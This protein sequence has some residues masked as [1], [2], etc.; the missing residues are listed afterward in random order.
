MPAGER[1]QPGLQRPARRAGGLPEVQDKVR[2]PGLP[3]G[4]LTLGPGQPRLVVFFAA[5]LAEVSNRRA[6]LLAL[7]RY[8]A[9]AKRHRLPPL[10]AVDE[11]AT[12]PSTATVR[13][14]LRRIGWPLGY[15]V[16]LDVTGRVADGYGV[17]DQP[18]FTLVSSSG[19]IAWS[20]DGWLPV[21]AL[22][23]AARRA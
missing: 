20:H 8:A 15:P 10:A 14:Y 7:N 4:T 17:Q 19:K 22:E 13:G 23:A 11:A 5:W 6:H 16:G 21:K 1:L 12:E 9:A 3:S 2:L 18:W